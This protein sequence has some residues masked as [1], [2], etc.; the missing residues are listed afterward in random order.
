MT[1]EGATVP[2][3]ALVQ[4]DPCPVDE[5]AAVDLVMPPPVLLMLFLGLLP[6]LLKMYSRKKKET[7]TRVQDLH[8]RRIWVPQRHCC[9]SS[10]ALL[11][12]C[13][14]VGDP[15]VNKRKKKIVPTDFKPRRSR[16]LA[17]LPLDLGNDSAATV[18]RHLGF[19]DGQG[20]ISLEDA[21]NYAKLFE[22]ALCREHVAAMATL[23]LA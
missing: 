15:Q 6:W 10:E 3:A 1:S 21:R 17:K 5:P 8:R 2:A 20:K 18:R 7:A 12:S 9:P 16:R 22:T 4:S 23:V 11:S 19:C 14:F 13:Y